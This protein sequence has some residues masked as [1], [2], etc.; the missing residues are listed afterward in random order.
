MRTLTFI[1]LI[2][3][4]SLFACKNS[5]QAM[6]SDKIEPSNSG[7]HETKNNMQEEVTYDMILSFISKGEGI[8]YT[9]KKKI[10]NILNSFNKKNNTNL[11]PETLAW[12]REGEI[13]YNFITKNLSTSQKDELT[14][15]VRETIGSSDMV[16]IT[17][18]QKSVHKR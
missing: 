16:H 11:K 12:G 8:D 3:T 13:D 17:F 7:K 10:D 2:A 14:S 6:D 18:N 9:L 5:S 1:I 4:S 15:Q